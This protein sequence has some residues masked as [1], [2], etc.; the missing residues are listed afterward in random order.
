MK[1]HKKKMQ[2]TWDLRYFGGKNKI[3]TLHRILFS[4]FIDENYLQRI[5]IF[6]ENIKINKF[7]KK[8]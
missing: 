6:F 8:N 2:R 4:G 1:K 5:K 3:G 7:S